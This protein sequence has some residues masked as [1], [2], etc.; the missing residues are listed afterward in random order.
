MGFVL[1]YL[2]HGQN[3]YLKTVT[4]VSV[5]LCVWYLCVMF[6]L[7]LVILLNAKKCLNC[8][9]WKALTPYL[10]HELTKNGERFHISVFANVP[11][12]GAILSCS[13]LGIKKGREWWQ[14]LL[15]QGTETTPKEKQRLAGQTTPPNGTITYS[16]EVH[17]GAGV[18]MSW[19]P[20]CSPQVITGITTSL[21]PLQNKD[22]DKGQ[23]GHTCYWDCST[24]HTFAPALI[25]CL[26]KACIC[27]QRRM[28]MAECLI[29]LFLHHAPFSAPHHVSER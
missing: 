2:V 23:A 9:S 17:P 24:M 27:T 18:I 1:F 10:A 3:F 28:K 4:S 16:D 14:H 22:W 15:C 12:P 6:F 26:V 7:L 13:Y 29:C 21:E 20:D 11:L 8:S 25:L 19:E 5:S